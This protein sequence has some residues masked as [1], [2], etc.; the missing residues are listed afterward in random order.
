M[1]ASLATLFTG[2][3][4]SN[5]FLLASAPPTATA[6]MIERAFAAG[7]G[8]AVI[9]TL[10]QVEE[11]PLTNVTPRICAVRHKK[12]ILGYV[13]NELGS[14][15]GID[16]WLE[17]MLRIKQNWPQ[18]AL[19]ASILYGGTPQE[20][21]WRDVSQKC[22]QAGADAL[23]LNF[24][25]PHGGAEEGGAAS[26]ADSAD[27]MHRVLGWVRHSTRLPIWVKLPAYCDL[28]KATRLCEEDG[29]QAITAINTLNCLPGINIHNSHPLLAVD[30]SGAFGGLSGPAIKPIALRSVVMARKAGGLAVSGVGGISTW[31]DAAEF[32]LAGAGSLQVCTAVMQRGYGII[33]TL[34]EGLAAWLEEREFANFSEAVGDALPHVVTHRALH[35]QYRVVASCD[36]ATCTRCGACAVSCRDSGFQAITWK[37]DH[38]PTIDST[39][40]DGC[41]LCASVCPASSIHMLC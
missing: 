4:L 6:D 24:S 5:P 8:G 35:R 30:G 3:P 16:H 13:N 33:D 32:V 11:K 19:V 34:C 29:A 10:A 37:K 21:Q 1:P 2:I 26:I 38:L 15:K 23:E 20:A 39:R 41:G 12:H 14:M 40:C 17:N 22:E 7:W 18:R 36:E 28:K 9:K 31:Q 27:A 25:C